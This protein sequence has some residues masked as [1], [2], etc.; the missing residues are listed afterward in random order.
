MLIAQEMSG[1]FDS[2]ETP[3]SVVAKLMGLSM[4]PVQ[5]K[6]Q[7]SKTNLKEIDSH[8]CESGALEDYWQQEEGSCNH[9]INYRAECCVHE[10]YKDAYEAK[11]HLPSNGLIK[12]HNLQ[13]EVCHENLMDKRTALVHQKFV[14]AKRLATNK[15]LIRSKEFKDALEVLRENR[16][17][18]LKF[19]EEPNSLFSKQLK[20]I[21]KIISFGSQNK[22]ITVLKSTTSFDSDHENSTRK[23]RCSC[24]E[25]IRRNIDAHGLSS[26]LFVP[27]AETTSQPTKIVVLKPSATVLRK[28]KTNMASKVSASAP[29]SR[30]KGGYLRT[31]DDIG[32]REVAMEITWQKLKDLRSM[33]KDEYQ[34]NAF[35]SNLYLA[36]ESTLNRSAND[37]KEEKGNDCSNSEL[38]TPTSQT[39]WVHVRSI[40]P[41]S[42]K[43]CSHQS[44]SAESS[45]REESL[46]ERVVLAT[47]NAIIHEEDIKKIPST[48]GDLLAIP[49]AK[50][51]EEE[52]I[53]RL[54]ISPWVSCDEEQDSSIANTCLPISRIQESS[55]DCIKNITRSKSLPANE[56]IRVNEEISCNL[57][58]K[59]ILVK[60]FSKL[61]KGKSFKEKVSSLFFSRMKKLVNDKP[62]L[63]T[64]VS[65]DGRLHA[66]SSSTIEDTNLSKSS[67]DGISDDDTSKTSEERLFNFSSPPVS[68]NQTERHGN[69]SFKVSIMN[70]F[71]FII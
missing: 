15:R 53:D 2:K 20:E 32:S 59:S 24:G 71:N 37:C 14:L 70:P 48:L 57:P 46:S 26:S 27:M 42:V 22:R 4:L 12:N 40:N 30:H 51:E 61:K 33:Q 62:K 25:E 67:H 35:P 63:S 50:K 28:T 47:S 3:P 36:D 52:V 10:K 5:Q 7:A 18:F 8:D 49:E 68:V 44:H 45:E 43:S 11:Q 66:A 65:S 13:H 60:E 54:A 58:S 31:D 38:A 34:S 56:N 1:A 29:E 69:V 6:V 16:D 39:T 41:D 17:L 21:Q 64:S 23:D 9:Q 55:E 19:L